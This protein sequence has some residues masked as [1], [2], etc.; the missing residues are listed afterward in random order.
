M[1]AN[2]Y[3]RIVCGRRSDRQT[4]ILTAP[5]FPGLGESVT[6]PNGKTLEV[7]KVQRVQGPLFSIEFPARR[8]A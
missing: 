2:E 5:P 1:K 7:V 3:V 8:G 4:F 6:L